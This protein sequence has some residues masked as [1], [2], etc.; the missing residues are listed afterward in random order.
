MSVESTSLNTT[1]SV[2]RYPTPP[3]RPA[4]A[5]SVFLNHRPVLIIT[6]PHCSPRTPRSPVRQ[7]PARPIPP[8]LFDRAVRG[9]P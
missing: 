5:D 8:R 3:V 9:E 6:L 7:C 2:I 4:S 1:G